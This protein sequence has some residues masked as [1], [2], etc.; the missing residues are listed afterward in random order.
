MSARI[1]AL[2]SKTSDKTYIGST[3]NKL[4]NR[5]NHHTGHY[6]EYQQ[7]KRTNN[8]SFEIMKLGD[9][10]IELLEE[11][12]IDNRYERERYWINNTPNCVNVIVR[13]RRSD[14]EKKQYH[15]EWV[16]DHK[17]SLRE[18]QRNYMREYRAKLKHESLS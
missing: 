6:K 3:T 13:P 9:A 14:D 15:K 4:N 17:E 7:G 5:F 2:R 11:C 1:Y 8:T 18:Y 12:N 10:Y 16:T